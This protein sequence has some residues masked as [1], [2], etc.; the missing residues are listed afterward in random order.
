MEILIPSLRVLLDSQ[1][2]EGEW[3]KARHDELNFLDERCMK[4]MDNLKKYQLRMARAFN[5]NVKPRY[6][7]EG[8]LVFRE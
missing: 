5:K 8:E 3:V 7:E 6:I 4:A 2:P 1:L